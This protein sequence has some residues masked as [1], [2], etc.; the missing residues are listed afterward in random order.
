VAALFD[1]LAV[2]EHDHSVG[3]GG[4]GQP[5]RDQDGAATGDGGGRGL[6]ERA[7]AGGAGLG[8]RVVE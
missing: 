7:G 4:L 2:L 5:V 3:A 6:L 8:G 1:H